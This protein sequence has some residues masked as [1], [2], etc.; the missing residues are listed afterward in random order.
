MYNVQ[1]AYNLLVHEERT[2][3]ACDIDHFCMLSGCHTLKDR[4]KKSSRKVA[5][6][7]VTCFMIHLEI[8]E[9]CGQ[10]HSW[11][12]WQRTLSVNIYFISIR[13]YPIH[14]GPGISHTLFLV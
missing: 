14:F 3:E 9:Y 10:F 12:L 7:A 6:K 2:N 11:G 8:S 5:V 13:I 1:C 4:F